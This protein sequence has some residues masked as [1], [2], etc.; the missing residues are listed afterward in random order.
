MAKKR[1]RQSRNSSRSIVWVAAIAIVLVLLIVFGGNLF[2]SNTGSTVAASQLIDPQQYQEQFGSGTDHLLLDVRTPEEFASGHIEGAVNINVETLASRLDEVPTD[3]PVVI[4]CR[5]G[6]R[7]ATASQILVG[8][9]YEGVYDLGG[10]QTWVA[11]GLP[12][13]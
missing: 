2:G 10:I 12:V 4:Y 7:S 5:S 3:V 8:A 11:Q 1:K 6:N 9:G 13:K